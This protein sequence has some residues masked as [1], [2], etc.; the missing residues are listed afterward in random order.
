MTVNTLSHVNK[1]YIEDP[2]VG[3]CVS[4]CK[5]M[6]CIHYDSHLAISFTAT[7]V[8]FNH[9]NVGIKRFNSKQVLLNDIGHQP[10]RTRI[11]SYE[12]QPFVHYANLYTK[13]VT[14]SI[15]AIEHLFLFT[16]DHTLTHIPSLDGTGN[17]EV[18]L[19]SYPKQPVF[20]CEPSIP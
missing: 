13:V 7:H 12:K 17:V 15:S 16:Q 20:P 8:I 2:Q 1:C 9:R 5:C 3:V 11:V 19:S 14:S 6:P 4:Q 18:V 10:G